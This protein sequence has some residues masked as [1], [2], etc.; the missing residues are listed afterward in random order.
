MDQHYHELREH[1]LDLRNQVHDR[2]DDHNHPMAH[3]LVH[4]TNQLVE[5]IES[6]KHP[7]ALEDR[8]KTI[9]RELHGLRYE[10]PG[11][12]LMSHGDL[13]S[14]HHAY[15]HQRDMIRRLPNR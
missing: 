8:I 13:E 6:Q 10:Q 4:E 7:R 12:T 3:I 14:F 9:Q 1:A 2:I 15:E 5:D 11:H